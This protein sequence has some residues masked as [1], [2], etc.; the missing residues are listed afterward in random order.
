MMEIG[1]QRAK[2]LSK[3][4]LARETPVQ[5]VASAKPQSKNL[6][7]TLVEK[8]V[9]AKPQSKMGIAARNPSQWRETP[10][11]VEE[12]ETPASTRRRLQMGFCDTRNWGFA[13]PGGFA[14]RQSRF[15]GPD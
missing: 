14:R 2:P 8:V 11:T 12:P 6:R 3:N 5:K 15:W 7:E 9:R 1:M 13:H 10:A 4:L